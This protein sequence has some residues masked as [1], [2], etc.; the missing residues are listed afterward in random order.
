MIETLLKGTAVIPVLE[1]AN[2][3]DAKPLAHALVKG[4]IK[5]AEL[6][7][8][9]PVA[10][11]AMKAMQ[12]AEPGLTVGMGSILNEQMVAETV[13]AG[14][15]FL[16]SPG[17]PETLAKSLKQSG[18]PCLPGV[19]TVTEALAIMAHGFTA[20][21]FFPAEAAGG[22]PYLKA[23]SGPVKNL[24]FCPTGGIGK[25]DVSR[26]LALKNVMCVGG[27]WIATKDMI[28]S[29]DW[30]AVADN[31]SLATSFAST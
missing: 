28:A 11:D 25:D 22:I 23:L 10:L 26:Y 21:K 1:V 19:S 30:Q 24:S 8:R 2:I 20:A 7:R 17:T 4:G 12:D 27:S 3:S 15:A 13:E 18:L 6:T 29:G 9:T 16:V 14:A 31:A 5:V